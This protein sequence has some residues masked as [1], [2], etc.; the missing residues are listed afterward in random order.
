VLEKD[1][2]GSRGLALESEKTFMVTD[3]DMIN[4]YDT[5]TYKEIE[6]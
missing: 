1:L 3:K 5:E 4:F 6:N 2:D